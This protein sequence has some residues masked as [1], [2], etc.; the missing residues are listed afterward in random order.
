MEVGL[1]AGG[2]F[3]EMSDFMPGVKIILQM[4]QQERGI[5][6]Y[7]NDSGIFPSYLF[8]IQDDY[9]QCHK[10]NFAFQLFVDI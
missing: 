9:R 6:E 5:S 1:I 3:T 8:V 4:T 7:L 10:Q 2:S